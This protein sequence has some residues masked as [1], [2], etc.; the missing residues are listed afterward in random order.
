MRRTGAQLAVY[1]LEQIGVKFTFGIPGTHTTE[2]YDA[3]NKSEQITPVLVT[4]EGGGSFMA[5][6][7]SRTSDSIG[8]L[9]I[10]P[11]AGLTHAMSGIGE[12]FLDGIP[13]LILAGGTHRASGKSYQLHQ[14]DQMALAKSITKAQFLIEKHEDV[15]STIFK[16]YDIAT[17]DEPGPVFIELP[18]NLQLFTGEVENLPTYNAVNR[19]QTIDQTSIDKAVKLLKNAVNPMLFVGWGAVDATKETIELAELLAAPVSTTLQGKSAFPNNHPLYTSVGLGASSKP[20]AQWALEKHDVLLA[21]GTRF[22]E[23]ATGSYGLEPPQNLIHIDI[24]PEVFNKNFSAEV[25]IQAD[26]KQ[27][28]RLLLEGLKKL[29]F[30]ASRSI[31]EAGKKIKDENEKYLKNWLKKKKENIV[32]PGH[33]FTSLRSHLQE[34][35]IMVVDDGKH[36]FLASELFQVFKPR[37]FISPTDFNCMGYCVPATIAAKMANPQKQVVGIVGDGAFQMTGLEAIT[38]AA[39]RVPVIFFIFNDGELGQISQFQKIP[40]NRKT[41][42]II[43]KANFEGVALAT[44]AEYLLLE[45]DHNID[46]VITKALDLAASGK[47]VM[48]DIKIDYSQK[49]MLTKGVVKVNLKRFPFKEKVRFLGRALGR[50]ILG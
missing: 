4:H 28:L 20:S 45:N 19:S 8:V 14:F 50:H 16:A 15:I 44:G 32:S 35:A 43:G 39:Y 48:V 23:I 10:V 17:S 42:S 49:T 41:C 47:H 25:T 30:S 11:A 12:A 29:E 18:V 2:L 7:I 5:D 46:S 27:A 22:G 26:A 6:A 31:S 38:A 40:L 24:N 34:D 3:M 9:T 21:V 36:T 13:M 37:H 1:A 33:F